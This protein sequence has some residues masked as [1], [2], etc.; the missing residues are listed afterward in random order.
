MNEYVIMIQ[1][2]SNGYVLTV[3]MKQQNQ[4]A[5]LDKV[6]QGRDPMLSNEK[7]ERKIGEFVETPNVFIFDTM[8]KVL[9]F[10]AKEYCD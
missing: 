10:L 1:R 3:P 6:L 2:V 5:G 9:A 4:F 7:E 8:E